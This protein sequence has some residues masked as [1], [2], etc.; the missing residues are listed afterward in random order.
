MKCIHQKYDSPY[1]WFMKFAC[2]K[3][4]SPKDT[5]R[6]VMN[7]MMM[8][9]SANCFPSS[10]TSKEFRPILALLHFVQECKYFQQHRS[11]TNQLQTKFEKKRY[12]RSFLDY[13]LNLHSK[14]VLGRHWHWQEVPPSAFQG[15]SNQIDN[16]GLWLYNTLWWSEHHQCVH[17][18]GL[19]DSTYGFTNN[20]AW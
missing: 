16:E 19:S 11:Q 15:S 4:Y 12:S 8:M 14:C 7:T 3:D 10:L 20:S 6:L 1:F 18:F 13:L 2:Q 5:W 17:V 9:L